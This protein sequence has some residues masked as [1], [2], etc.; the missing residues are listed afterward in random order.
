MGVEADRGG[1]RALAGTAGIL[2]AREGSALLEQILPAFPKGL[3]RGQEVVGHHR[4]LVSGTLEV[5][6]LLATFSGE[7]SLLSKATWATNR[8]GASSLGVTGS[9]EPQAPFWAPSPPLQH[10]LCFVARGAD[11]TT[12]ADSGYTPMDLAVALGYRKGQP[13]THGEVT[14]CCRWGD[15]RGYMGHTSW[16]LATRVFTLETLRATVYLAWA[17]ARPSSQGAPYDLEVEVNVCQ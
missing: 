15:Q 1:P 11:L 16:I 10:L 9:P 8:P 17:C 14:G 12:E 4:G 3:I 6:V 7:L 5:G 13:E 2:R